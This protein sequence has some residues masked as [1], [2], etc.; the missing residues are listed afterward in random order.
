HLARR[1]LPITL[2]LGE[3]CF[4]RKLW[5][6]AAIHL[7]SLATHPDA[8]RHAPQVALGLVRAGQAEIRALKPAN[9]AKHYEAAVQIDPRCAPAWHQLGVLATA[10]GDMQ[11]A[12]ECLE[13]EADAT[14]EP[15][16]RVRLYDALGDLAQG[17]LD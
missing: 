12:A 2:A 15:A 11:R 10:G 8:A 16:A 9:A 5:R 3:S 6:E 1:D 4:Q 17:V 7:G 13:K 14:T